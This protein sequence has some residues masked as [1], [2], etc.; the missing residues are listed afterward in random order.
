MNKIVFEDMVSIADDLGELIS[1]F[2]GAKILVTG[3]QGFLGSNFL[4]FFDYINKEVLKKKA[5]I[6]CID[7]GIV[8]LEDQTLE[9]SKDFTCIKGD[10]ANDLP[11]TAFDYI[12]HCA[13]IASPTYYRK[14][15]LETISVNAISYWDMLNKIRLEN[16]KG[17]LYFSTSEIY[18]DPDTKH[19]PTA[20]EYRGNVSCTGPRACYD[21]SKRLGETIS[22]CFAKQKNIPIKIVRPFNVYGPFMRLDD[23]RVVPDFAKFAL[24]DRLI[25]IFSDGSPMRAFCYISDALSGFL[26]VLL[27]GRPGASY[28]IG[29]D[30][31]EISMLQLAENVSNIVGDVKIEL[32][33]NKEKDYL[34]DNPRRR[35]PNID[36]AK[37]ELTYCP[38]ISTDKGLA[39]IINWYKQTY[40][41][42][43]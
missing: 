15:P 10:A 43:D 31:Q 23:K 42:E 21:E 11:D 29:N 32:S 14:Y 38:K 33:V 9:F 6:T 26:R 2:E 24:Q 3:Y 19:I 37:K 39:R 25:R 8:D 5:D 34:T 12:I 40:L 35:C 20:E 7:N 30:S 4:A 1:N 22:V 16:I 27:V 41:T 17:L 36:K 13:G 28:N 18:G